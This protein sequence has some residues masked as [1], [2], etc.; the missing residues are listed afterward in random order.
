MSSE[1]CTLLGELVSF[2]DNDSGQKI[3]LVEEKL[4]T[5]ALR[6]WDALPNKFE[7][8]LGEAGDEL[9]I[10]KMVAFSISVDFYKEERISGF[11][12]HKLLSLDI[13][14]DVKNLLGSILESNKAESTALPMSQY[15]TY[16]GCESND[17]Y[18][19][20]NSIEYEMTF[21]EES[22]SHRISPDALKEPS[23]YNGH[24]SEGDTLINV[25]KD[26]ARYLSIGNISLIFDKFYRPIRGL[27]FNFEYSYGEAVIY[28]IS[29][30]GDIIH[31]LKIDKVK[32]T[33][34]TSRDR[35]SNTETIVIR[36]GDQLSDE[37]IK[38]LQEPVKGHYKP[39][40]LFDTHDTHPVF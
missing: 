3:I 32:Y 4:G 31:T 29:K 28:S 33:A 40:V 10:G 24:G 9:L 38:F 21:I 7:I 8:N 2:W 30:K 17:K 39:R 26:S 13:E 1:I 20:F 6:K 11:K 34:D 19:I 36:L 35:S 12:I 5:I 18:F 25:K 16:V 15:L 23:V 14:Y 27:G 22:F 37:M